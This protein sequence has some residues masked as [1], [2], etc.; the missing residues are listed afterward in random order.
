MHDE[1]YYPPQLDFNLNGYQRDEAG[2][3]ANV[4]DARTI[5]RNLQQI[6]R[7]LEVAPFDQLPLNTQAEISLYLVGTYLLTQPAGQSPDGQPTGQ[8]ALLE[9]LFNEELAETIHREKVTLDT[10]DIL[11]SVERLFE[12]FGK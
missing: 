11:H 4:E 3:V 7:F 5:I 10:A 12:D 8:T 6:I 2:L 1:Q 9:S